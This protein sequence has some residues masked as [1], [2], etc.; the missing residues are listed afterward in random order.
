MRKDYKPTTN[1]QDVSNIGEF[2]KNLR[3]QVIIDAPKWS[4]EPQ[5][6]YNFDASEQYARSNF[7]ENCDESTFQKAIIDFTLQGL[8]SGNY[9][10]QAYSAWVLGVLANV[11]EEQNQ[12]NVILD[13]VAV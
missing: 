13:K 7:P 4:S 5:P 9:T 6:P 1:F 10:E 3:A 11:P 2:L 12:G 8:S